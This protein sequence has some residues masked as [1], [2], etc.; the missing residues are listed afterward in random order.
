M[1]SCITCLEYLQYTETEKPEKYRR[2]DQQIDTETDR[3][4][5]REIEGSVQLY[6]HFCRFR[7]VL[8]F[9]KISFPRAMLLLEALWFH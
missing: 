6:K 3:Q 9:P 2:T 5:D 1:D 7:D 4:T 8:H